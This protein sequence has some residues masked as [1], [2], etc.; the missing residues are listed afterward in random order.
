MTCFGQQGTNEHVRY[1]ISKGDCMYWLRILLVLVFTC[2]S[3][4]AADKKEITVVDQAGRS[5]VIRQPVERVVTTFIPATLFALSAGLKDRLVGASSKDVSNS[6]Y[7]ALINPDAPPKLVGNRSVGL[8]LETITSLKPDLIIM[9][10]QKDGVRTADRLTKLG[11][12]AIVIFPESLDDMQ[13]ILNLIGV[14]ADNTVHTDAVVKE[15]A[16]IAENVAARVASKG[17]PKVYY[18]TSRLLR[19]VSG[20]MMQHQMI[21]IAGGKNVSADLHGFFSDISKEQL[22]IWNPDIIL[23]SDR[24]REQEIERLSSPELSGI[25][26]SKERKIYRVPSQTYWD[27]PSPLAMAGVIWMSSKIHPEVYQEDQAQQEIE[28]FYDTLFGPGFSAE[29]PVVVGKPAR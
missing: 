14:A 23:C 25:T 27:F 7:E 22:L 17:Q 11:F 20:D 15:M 18:A 13:K 5:V 26:A 1:F 28:R 19:T 24:L 10:G 3:C 2:S 8:N 29:H 12:P 21:S 9:Y 4:I 6:I 16:K